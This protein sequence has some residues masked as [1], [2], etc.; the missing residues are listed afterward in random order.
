M[1]TLYYIYIYICVYNVCD[2][3]VDEWLVADEALLVAVIAHAQRHGQANHHQQPQDLITHT[4]VTGVRGYRGRTPLSVRL[5]GPKAGR[6]YT[7]CRPCSCYTLTCNS[8]YM[9]ID[10]VLYYISDVPAAVRGPT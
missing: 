10:I 3:E 2:L 9:Y 1:I 8:I 4:V 5:H 7:V 6:V